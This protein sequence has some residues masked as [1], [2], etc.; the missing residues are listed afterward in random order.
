MLRIVVY[1]LCLAKKDS[2]IDYKIG[3]TLRKSSRRLI[4]VSPRSHP[5]TRHRPNFSARHASPQNSSKI[6]ASVFKEDISG[7]LRRRTTKEHVE[8]NI[9]EGDGKVEDE[10]DRDEEEGSR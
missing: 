1:H 7:L 4:P 8:E 9:G 5:C 3:R 6:Y 10:L 2:Q